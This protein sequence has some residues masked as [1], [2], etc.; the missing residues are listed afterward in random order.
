MSYAASRLTLFALISSIEDDL[1]RLIRSETHSTISPQ[2]AL[3]EDIYRR[4]LSRRQNDYGDFDNPSLHNLLYYVDF[5]DLFQTLNRNKTEISKSVAQYIKSITSQL[6]LVTPIRNRV[7]HARPLRSNDFPFLWDLAT[8]LVEAKPSTWSNLVLTLNKLRENPSYVLGLSIPSYDTEIESSSH[9]L[10]IP[11]FD[12]T[13][14][15]GRSDLIDQVTR[16]CF[17]PY[18]VITIVGEGGIGKTSLAL[19]VAYD[20]LDNPKNLFDAVVWVSCKTRQLTAKNIREI[21]NSIRDSLGLFEAVSLDLAGVS[22]SNPVQEVLDCLNEFRVLLII[23]NLETVLDER[24]RHFLEGIPSGTKILITSRIGL[25]AFEYPIKMT[26]M[27]EPEAVELLRSLS[28]MRGVHQILPLNNKKL[29]T[30]CRRMKHNPGYIKWFV[31]AVQAGQAPETVLG[32]PEIFLEFCMTNVYG[33]LSDA[34]KSVLVVMQGASGK[35][36]LAELSYL[37]GDID[38]LELQ[39]SL[40]ELLTTNMVHMTST[41]RGSSFESRYSITDLARAYLEK[42]HP[43]NKDQVKA[44]LGKRK[45][46]ASAGEEIEAELKT[47]PYSF[48]AIRLRSKNDRIIAKYLH[49]ALKDIRQMKFS[50]AAEKIERA[51]ALA[52]EYFEV[53]RVEAYLSAREGKIPAAMVAYEAALELSPDTAPLR[54]WY[55]GFLLRYLDDTEEALRQFDLASQIDGSAHQIT[56]ER[57]RVNLYLLKFDDARKLLD[58]LLELQDLPEWSRRKTYDLHLQ[59]YQRLADRQASLHDYLESLSSLEQLHYEYSCCP[60]EIVDARMLEKLE[61]SIYTALVCSRALE[62]TPSANR[63]SAVMAKLEKEASSLKDFV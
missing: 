22:S 49:G 54:Y 16:L 62:K 17:G 6:S 27:E 14:Y 46:L 37:S 63:A 43:L 45:E 60:N 42:R 38:P 47:N 55:G 61:R 24:I 11:D 51:R 15:I 34:G 28:R 39:V 2:D 18:P 13:G 52:P 44:L 5:Q 57:A 58:Q 9:N 32:Q 33:Y 29:A 26:S 19:R 21:D 23:D 1:R 36:S 56:L 40:Q 41:P 30:F 31:S 59:Y 4:A 3:G 50:D 7:S 12:E 10:P 35:H 8:Q 48:F 20:I 53:Y 25:G